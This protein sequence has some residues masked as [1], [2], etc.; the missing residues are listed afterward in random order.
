MTEGEEGVGGADDRIGED[1]GNLGE[2]RDLYQFVAEPPRAWCEKS[3]RYRWEVSLSYEE[4]NELVSKNL[5]Q[6]V[7]KPGLAVGQLQSLL[8][9]R[10]GE[11]GRVEEFEVRA[12]GRSHLVYG[13]QA[14]W[15]FG[16]GKPSVKGLPSTLFAM[17]VEF[18]GGWLPARFIFRGGGW[19]HGRGLCQW[20]AQGRATAG[21]SAEEIVKAYY[22][23]AEIAR[24][25]AELTGE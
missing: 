9:K 8:I 2:E 3:P 4:A 12:G 7:G 6:L 10:R 17:E 21:A 25:K 22:P 18:E 19:G 24:G 15:L 11:R 20:G 14:R 13:D 16:E 23:G 5:G 1:R